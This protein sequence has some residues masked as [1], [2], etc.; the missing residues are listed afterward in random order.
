MGFKIAVP[1]GIAA[2]ALICAP[3]AQADQSMYRIGTDIAPGD[4][5]YTVTNSGGSWTLCSTANCSGD[6][7]IDIDV[8]MGRGAKGYLTV[9]ATAKYL[10]VT[11][12][13]LRPDQ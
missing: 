1:V 8:I 5:T 12:L 13:A 11:D 9:P 3:A 2:A 6:A 10:K 7:I 4:Y